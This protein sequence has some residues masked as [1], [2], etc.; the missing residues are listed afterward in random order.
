M[1]RMNFTLPSDCNYRDDLILLKMR[2][3]DKSQEAKVFLEEIQRKDK[4][5]RSQIKENKK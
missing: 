2:L 4:S 5:L 1:E 3:T